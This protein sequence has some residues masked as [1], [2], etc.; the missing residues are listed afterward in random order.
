MLNIILI[1]I[2]KSNFNFNKYTKSIYGF[3]IDN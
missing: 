2:K 1:N 3:Y